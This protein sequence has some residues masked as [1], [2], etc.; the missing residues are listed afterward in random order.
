MPGWS[1]A[2]ICQW[3]WPSAVRLTSRATRLDPS[4]W[5]FICTMSQSDRPPA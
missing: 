3:I 4:V 2:V 1:V 5:V